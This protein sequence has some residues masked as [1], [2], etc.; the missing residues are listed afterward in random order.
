MHHTARELNSGHLTPQRA[1][2]F[3]TDRS[4][5]EHY[6]R[7]LHSKFNNFGQGGAWLTER[8]QAIVAMDRVPCH[9]EV[10]HWVRW[11]DLAL[12]TA[13][14]YQW[15]THYLYYEDYTEKYNATIEALYDFVGLVP[16]HPPKPFETGKIYRHLFTNEEME[17]MTELVQEVASPECWALLRRYFE[18]WQNR[19]RIENVTLASPIVSSRLR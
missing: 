17:L 15:S 10:L 13:T 9:N 7:Y 4:G 6:C 5:L 11:H 18:P 14:E 16:T 1:Q 19:T 3:T 2:R 8:A 12:K